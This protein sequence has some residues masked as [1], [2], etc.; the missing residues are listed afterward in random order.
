MTEGFRDLAVWQR[1]LTV[2]EQIYGVTRAFPPDERYGLTS[3]MRRASVSIVSNIAEGRGRFSTREYVRFIGIA[4][5]S[6]AELESQV[7]IARRLGFL[8]DAQC[9]SL[10]RELDELSRMLRGLKLSLDNR[11]HESID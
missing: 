5:G 6:A 8:P 9:D 1:A 11:I 7:E 3:Q 10:I 2:C 4:R